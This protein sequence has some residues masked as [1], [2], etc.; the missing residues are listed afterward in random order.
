[1][2]HICFDFALNQSVHK[3]CR[4]EAKVYG[5][6]SVTLFICDS[7]WSKVARE[8]VVFHDCGELSGIR[9]RQRIRTDWVAVVLRLRQKLD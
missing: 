5:R 2:V 3:A 7:A 6:S 9:V 1:M 4:R 8:T